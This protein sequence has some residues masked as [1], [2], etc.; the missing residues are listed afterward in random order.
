MPCSEINFGTDHISAKYNYSFYDYEDN[1]QHSDTLDFKVSMFD[2]FTTIFIRTDGGSESVKYWNS[3]VE[4]NGFKIEIK[5][6]GYV[7]T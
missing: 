4:K 6:F 2:N 5:P 1:V 7:N 3:F